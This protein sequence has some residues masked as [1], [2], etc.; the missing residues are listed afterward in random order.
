MPVRFPLEDVPRWI[1]EHK[2]YRNWRAA[3]WLGRARDPEDRK[4]VS[5]LYREARLMRKRGLDVVVDHIEP[6]CSDWVCGLS[7]SANLRIVYRERNV[8]KSNGTE[9]PDLFG[10]EMQPHQW[11]L[12]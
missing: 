11:S 3:Q 2:D 12:L 10:Y 1:R 4:R 8:R 6:L 7:H 9:H 5:K